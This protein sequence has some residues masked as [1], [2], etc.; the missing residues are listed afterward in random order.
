M[1]KKYRTFKLWPVVGVVS[2]IL[3]IGI[4]IFFYHNFFRQYNAD[5]VETVP[6]DA[7]F[8]FQINDNDAFIRNS[9]SVL[10]YL[11]EIFCMS[12]LPGF[13]FIME[14]FSGRI[15]V[16]ISCH[17]NGDKSQLLL[18]ANISEAA[19]RELL[20]ALKI[21]N[22]NFIPFDKVKIYSY[23]TH[24]KKFSFSFHNNVF[25]VS[26]D[27]E[28]LKKSIVQLK[29]PR[30]LLANKEFASLYQLIS[31]NAKQNWLILNHAN[32]FEQNKHFIRSSYHDVL[33]NIS[34]ASEWSAF[35]IRFA[36]KEIMLAGYTLNDSSFY[37]KFKDQ[38]N[39]P[40]TPD[41]VIP[42]TSSFYCISKTPY[43]QKFFSGFPAGN[44]AKLQASLKA[45]ELIQPES[46]TLFTLEKDSTRLY[47]LALALDT[48]RIKPRTFLP[49]SLLPEHKII[50]QQQ[51]I[52]KTRLTDFNALLS[53][54]IHQDAS[55]NYY[56]EYKGYYIF[57][58][59]VTTL[60][61]Y[62]NRIVQNSFAN[63]PLYR[64]SKANLPSENIFEFCF[65]FPDQQDK[66]G[67]YFSKE[68][69]NTQTVKDIQIFSGSFSVPENRYVPMN[70]Y[71]K[72]R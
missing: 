72:F 8:I 53:D 63:Q 5:L 28:L 21:D 49:D 42:F 7:S 67:E 65:L 15:P 34:K 31:K 39:S 10:P 59:T 46:T 69:L 47:Y 6:S 50:H 44:E 4:G 41:V 25:T 16:I 56:V 20:S 1:K 9:S 61:Y 11:D 19:F 2:V 13:E 37:N 55:L 68:S 18:S 36:D 71:L 58:D 64:F 29:H 22:R 60:Q 51:T 35:Q 48:N 62:L 24:Y 57:S 14:K 70:L 27:I 40:G 45:Y 26:E 32:F 38:V 33:V 17:H 30:N 23:G 52:Y 43:P 12:A 54:G 66:A 3:V